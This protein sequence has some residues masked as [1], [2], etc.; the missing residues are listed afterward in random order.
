MFGVVTAH[1]GVVVFFTEL[2]YYYS[3][4]ERPIGYTIDI[5]TGAGYFSSTY[6][7]VSVINVEPNSK[8]V[9]TFCLLMA[10]YFITDI[11]YNNVKTDMLVHH[12]VA[13]EW[14][15]F[16]GVVKTY[17]FYLACAMIVELSTVFLSALYIINKDSILHKITMIV[18]AFVFFVVRIVLIPVLFTLPLC[19]EP[20]DKVVIIVAGFV[21]F[22]GVNIYWF[23]LV[24]RKIYRKIC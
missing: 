13:I 23:I 16:Q 22:Y 20:F 1:R 12:M 21:P 24:I 7:H 10:A 9:F 3:I 14:V 17:S 18:F 4:D 11:F 2:Y 15:I 19:I 5:N 8:I 6:D